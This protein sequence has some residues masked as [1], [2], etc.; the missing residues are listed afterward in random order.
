MCLK[1]LDDL[2]ASREFTVGLRRYSKSGV[3]RFVWN[4]VVFAWRIF[5]TRS[6]GRVVG[7]QVP[8]VIIWSIMR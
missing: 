7:A 2:T 4:I 1:L 6:C 8:I 3:W 5:V